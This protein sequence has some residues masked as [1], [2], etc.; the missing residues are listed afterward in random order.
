MILFNNNI[1]FSNLM[2]VA[3]F[4]FFRCY[5]FILKPIVINYKCHDFVSRI[6]Q[7]V[8]FNVFLI[9]KLILIGG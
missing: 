1:W 3:F 5:V 8:L 9:N 6:M 7:C 4:F 2:N